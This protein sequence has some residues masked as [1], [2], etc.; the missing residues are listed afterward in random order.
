MC[1][2]N[3]IKMYL[4]FPQHLP[5]A[6]RGSKESQ[7]LPFQSNSDNTLMWLP[8]LYSRDLNAYLEHFLIKYWSHGIRHDVILKRLG[9]QHN[10]PVQELFGQFLQGSCSSVD[11]ENKMTRAIV[12]AHSPKT[13]SASAPSAFSMKSLKVGSYGHELG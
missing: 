2:N 6:S 11:L 3:K 10:L 8:M 4:P 12:T 7:L 9:R 1:T 5:C 13:T